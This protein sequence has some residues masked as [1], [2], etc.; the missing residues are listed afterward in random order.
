MT[1]PGEIPIDDYLRIIGYKPKASIARKVA[2]S[3]SLVCSLITGLACGRLSF[4]HAL[5]KETL[6]DVTAPNKHES[7]ITPET[8]HSVATIQR[9]AQRAIEALDVVHPPLLSRCWRR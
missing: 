7:L 2:V 8:Q 6:S 9:E 5:A 1:I 4:G 3:I